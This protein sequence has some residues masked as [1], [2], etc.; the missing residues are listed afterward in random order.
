MEEKINTSVGEIFI[1][2]DFDRAV[3]K[4]VIEDHEYERWGD[5]TIKDHDLVV[6][7]G[8]HIGSFTRLALSKGVRVLA[9]EADQEN[10]DM[11]VKNTENSNNVTLLKAILWNG[12][13]KKFLK[14]PQRGELN[15]VDDKGILMPTISIDQIVEKFD[16][17]RIDLLK[18]DIEGAEYEVLSHFKHLG[19]VQQ[20]TMEWHYGSTKMAE[21]II[22]L[23]K[24]GLTV[25]WEAGNGQWGKIQ[26]K[27]L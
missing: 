25:V 2:N 14:D 3:V 12:S 17:N 1:R 4:E 6:D 11:L 13:D 20:L 9:I 8:A 21:L 5:I 18:M 26:A 24:R 15:K 19:I 7:C 16:I 23:E 10:F 27:R 22:Y